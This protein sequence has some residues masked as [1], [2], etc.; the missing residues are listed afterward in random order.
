MRSDPTTRS[1][2]KK[3]QIVLVGIGE[4]TWAL[5]TSGSSWDLR[6]ARRAMPLTWK[7]SGATST[8]G[9]RAQAAQLEAG[10]PQGDH[11]AERRSRRQ[12]RSP[13]IRHARTQRLP[14]Q[15]VEAVHLQ[16]DGEASR[17]LRRCLL[18]VQRSRRKEERVRDGLAY[19]VSMLLPEW[20]GAAGHG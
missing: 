3:A 15:D 12:G 2:V 5:E 7:H 19:Q 13:P 14:G 8:R 10:R 18:S 9:S 6:E 11:L 4:Q 16:R 17:A 1:V 20:E